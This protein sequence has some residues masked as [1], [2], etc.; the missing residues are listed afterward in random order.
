VFKICFFVP[1]EHSE[2][3][4]AA[5]FNAGGGKIGSYECCSFETLGTGQFKPLQGA[6]PF[7][8]QIGVVEK[9][10]ELKVEMVCEN[11]CLKA[12]VE[13]MKENHP[14]EMPAYDII[15]LEDY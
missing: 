9:V 15:K 2:A 5:M 14:Y 11:H 13:A 3:V 6:N 7:I 1:V 4:K 10:S 12:V 8:G